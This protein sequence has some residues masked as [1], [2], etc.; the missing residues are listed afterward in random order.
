MLSH[1]VGGQIFGLN[2]LQPSVFIRGEH[3]VGVARQSEHLLPFKDHMVFVGMEGNA[4]IGQAAT[5]LGV[6]R[7]RCWLI[8]VVGKDGLRLDL[9]GQMGNFLQGVAV[10]NNEPQLRCQRSLYPRL[11]RLGPEQFVQFHQRFS[12]ESHPPVLGGEVLQDFGVK[13]EHAMHFGA[14]FEGV[15]QRSVVCNA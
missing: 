1:G 11:K 2:F 5:H 7:Q 10:Q 14:V 3:G 4:G 12:N 9:L 6:A 15:E 8:V 13:D